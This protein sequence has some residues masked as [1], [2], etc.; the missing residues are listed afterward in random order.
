M[1]LRTGR[2]GKSKKGLTWEKAL[3]WVRPMNPQP[4]IPTLS[5]FMLVP[6]VRVAHLNHRVEHVLPR[7]GLEQDG[8]G[9]HAAIPADVFDG[10]G[11]LAIGAVKHICWD[12][13]MFP[14]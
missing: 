7:L 1:V 2:Q 4:I 6:S 9:E 8:V 13:C 10:A 11:G 12:G 3:E 5:F 14:N